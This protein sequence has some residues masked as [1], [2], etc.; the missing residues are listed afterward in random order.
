[1]SFDD[2]SNRDVNDPIDQMFDYNHDGKMN[3]SEQAIAN[4][5]RESVGSRLSLRRGP[6]GILVFF[7]A[8]Y[9]FMLAIVVV[10]IWRAIVS[11]D[12]FKYLTISFDGAK[13]YLIPKAQ[14]AKDAPAGIKASD[15]TF[16]TKDSDRGVFLTRGRSF[17]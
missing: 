17:M 6:Y 5:Y 7:L 8:V 12:P 1:M 3:S 13:P 14:V 9:V 10:L 16:S 15:F 4:A 11:V 2:F